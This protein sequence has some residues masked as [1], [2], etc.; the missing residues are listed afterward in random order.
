MPY[1]IAFLRSDRKS[2]VA[3]MYGFMIL[4][5]AW[6]SEEHRHHLI[7]LLF[8]LEFFTDD[9][10]I[11]TAPRKSPAAFLMRCDVHGCGYGRIEVNS[12]NRARLYDT[13]F[14]VGIEKNIDI[15]LDEAR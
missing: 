3:T 4:C 12:H 6:V 11:K 7:K 2:N 15:N 14:R 8:F 5:P 1:T 10:V 9:L 13:M